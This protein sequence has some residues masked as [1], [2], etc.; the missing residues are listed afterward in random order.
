MGAQLLFLIA[1]RDSCQ[2]II[3]I[4]KKGLLE[5]DV[6]TLVLSSKELYDV[7]LQY[8]DIIFDFQFGKKK[9][10]NFRVTCN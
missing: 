4:Y 7:V 5:R 2:V 9:F 3:D 6:A 10:P 8:E 1:T